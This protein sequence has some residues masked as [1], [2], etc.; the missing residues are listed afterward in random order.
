MPPEKPLLTIAI[1]TYNRSRCLSGLLSTL[2]PQ[3]E[4][5]TSVE[6][7][8]SDNASPDDTA[9][10]I[11]R[12]CPESSRYRLLRN[13]VNIGADANFLQC[14]HE[15]RGRYFWLVGDD[16][17]LVPGSVE[18]V[19]RLLGAGDYDVAFVR[20]Y[21]FRERFDEVKVQDRLG[22]TAMVV[23]D[24][25]RFTEMTG[26]MLTF[27]SAVIVNKDRLTQS[28]APDPSAFIGTNLIQLGWVLPLSLIHI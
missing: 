4:K 9:E 15:A 21:A 3:L 24:S 28:A 11:H 26:V 16:D 25:E 13:A 23:E 5:E 14:F 7:V 17:I 8:I 6:L 1:P 19:R 2:M 27:I 18:K 12:L 20:P 10:V 22:R